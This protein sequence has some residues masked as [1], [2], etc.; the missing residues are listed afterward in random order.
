MKKRNR[1]AAITGGGVVTPVAPATLWP[2]LKAIE[3]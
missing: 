3:K 1:L 2:E